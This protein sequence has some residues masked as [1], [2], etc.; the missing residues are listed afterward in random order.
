MGLRIYNNVTALTALRNLGRSSER[1]GTSIERLSSGLRINTAGDD[2]AGLAISEKLHNQVLGLQ[3]ATLNAQDGASLLQTAEGAL[4]EVHSILQR[5]RQLAVQAANDTLTQQDRVEIQR[6]IDQLNEEINRISRTTEF[7]TKSLLDGSA[8][9]LASTDSP[10]EM[11]VIIR[12]VVQEGNYQITKQNVP[13]QA[14]VLKSDIF[15][16]V[17]TSK[18]PSGTRGLARDWGASTLF[19]GVGEAL[20]ASDLTSWRNF[21]FSHNIGGENNLVRDFR[22][23]VKQVA[24]A[25]DSQ[26]A[27]V[28]HYFKTQGG[29]SGFALATT[30]TLGAGD[31]GYYEI[32]VASVYSNDGVIDTSL[33]SA[34]LYELTA[35]ELDAKGGVIRTVH[36]DVTHAQASTAQDLLGTNMAGLITGG[37]TSITMGTDQCKWAV[38]DK[39]LVVVNSAADFAGTP[40]VQQVKQDMADNGFQVDTTG[41][42]IRNDAA[43]DR[44]GLYTSLGTDLNAID[45]STYSTSMA[46]YDSSGN[47]QMG[48]GDIRYGESGYTV[49]SAGG[50][51]DFY[52]EESTLAERTTTLSQV[53]KFQ[54][55]FIHGGQVVTIYNGKGASASFTLNGSDTLEKVAEKIRDAI[56]KPISQGGLGMG[57]DGDLSRS[58]GVDGNV[59]VFVSEPKEATD[60]ALPA[61]FVIRSTV[62]GKGGRLVF[63]ADQGVLDAFSLAQIQDPED[64][65]QVTVTDA[66]TG[67]LVGTT[68]VDDGVVRNLIKGVDLVIDQRTDS[69]VRFVPGGI[70]LKPGDVTEG[71]SALAGTASAA[72]DIVAGSATFARNMFQNFKGLDADAGPVG[73]PL[74]SVANFELATNGAAGDQFSVADFLFMASPPS[75]KTGLALGV[76]AISANTTAGYYTLEVVAINGVTAAGTSDTLTNID[77]AASGMDVRLSKYDRNGTLLEQATVNVGDTSAGIAV[78][79]TPLELFRRNFAGGTGLVTEGIANADSATVNLGVGA[80]R[81]Y[82]GDRIAFAIAN[83]SG[84][85]TAMLRNDTTDTGFFGT[86]GLTYDGGVTGAVS[87]APV[88]TGLVEVLG[89]ADFSAAAGTKAD[90]TVGY[91]DSAGNFLVGGGSVLL[92]Q[93]GDTIQAG[94]VQFSLTADQTAGPGF[95]FESAPGAAVEFVHLVDNRISLQ[96]GANEGQSMIAAISQLDTTA[97]GLDDLLVISRVFAQEALAKVDNA[98]NVVSSQRAKLGALINR[99][100]ATRSV[101]QIQSEN[102]LASE[103]RIR[104]LDIA[105]QTIEFTRD[106]ILTQA[107]TALLAQ[108]NALPQSVLQLLQ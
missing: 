49:R 88:R 21:E 50:S 60:E 22:I 68:T 53:D 33:G 23:E 77:T 30:G 78:T 70:T 84:S 80:D 63:S 47:R 69:L 83:A 79:N 8:T 74:N 54:D 13:G 4:S 34:N 25:A 75:A 52:L 24:G 108:A 73:S 64:P 31:S 17:A 1:L 40:Y 97:L 37:V 39:F 6:E 2:P 93:P 28:D 29:K 36:F 51:V 92:G 58:T 55:A 45:G 107:G 72:V 48:T 95:V 38:G 12:D 91:Y 76:P 32:E 100:E 61:T 18:N 62:P 87:G 66:H 19:Q 14:Q 27:I 5:M 3:R 96:V 65:M 26:V 85:T 101:L 44:V 9:A 105:S 71:G 102:L 10:N 11:Q 94:T 99:L 7:N 67:A 16:L 20:S 41:S 81:Y 82:V 90:V 57:I 35:R 106:Q 104:D 46:Y 86:S 15:N 103:S 59:C 98:V 42:G 56:I 89:A 43:E